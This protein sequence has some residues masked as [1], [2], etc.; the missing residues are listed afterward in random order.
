MLYYYYFIRLDLRSMLYYYYFI[1]LDLRSMLYY[2]FFYQI[3]FEEYAV[4]FEQCKVDG[5]LLLMLTEEDLNSSL[6]MNCRI[7]HKR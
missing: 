2:Y 6:K 4:N 5:D 7:T 3:G 1:G